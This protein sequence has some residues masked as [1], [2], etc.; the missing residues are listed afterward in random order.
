V[1]KSSNVLTIPKGIVTV[2][3]SLTEAPKN[4]LIKLFKQAKKK[5]DKIIG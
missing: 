3:H 1:L 2:H 4:L 5:M